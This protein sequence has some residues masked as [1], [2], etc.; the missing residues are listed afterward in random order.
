MNRE[1]PV[2][3]TVCQSI[4]QK[5]N[6]NNAVRSFTEMGVTDVIPVRVS[7]MVKQPIQENSF[8]ERLVWRSREL[9]K[10]SLR[11]IAPTIHDIMDFADAVKLIKDYDVAILAY[12]NEHDPL[13]TVKALARCKNAK[14]IIIFIGSE[15]GFEPHEVELAQDAGAHIV[16][17]G[18]RIIRASNAGAI[19]MGML[20]YVLELN[21]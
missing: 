8:K 5:E 9:V 11:E 14:S 15:L 3:V 20:V 12:E 21:G 2:K 10:N 17:L 4:L 19:L 6:M 18:N 13:C 7:R 16:S 1:L